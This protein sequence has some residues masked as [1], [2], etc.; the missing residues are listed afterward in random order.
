[1]YPNSLVD[2]AEGRGN[3]NYESNIHNLD[4]VAPH[5]FP[6]L[7][8]GVVK[9][10]CRLK[11]GCVAP[12]GRKRPSSTPASIEVPPN[13]LYGTELLMPKDQNVVGGRRRV[14]WTEGPGVMSLRGSS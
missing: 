10:V 9:S 5:K 13:S 1:M 4:N 3:L 12:G 6:Q 8:T 2:E 14:E 11:L 7:T